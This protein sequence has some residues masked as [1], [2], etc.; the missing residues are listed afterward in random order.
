[1]GPPRVNPAEYGLAAGGGRLEAKPKSAAEKLTSLEDAV[2]RIK[3]GDHVAVGGCLFSRTPMA[4]VRELLRQRRRGLTLSRNLTCTEG[5]SLMVAGAV[6]R[7][8]T[9]WMS[10]GLPWGVSKILRHFVE[11]GRFPL[12]DWRHLAPGLRFRA[13]AMG[14]P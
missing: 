6:E 12:E 5:E 8:V 14:L 10:I 7:I 9:A 13:P 2:A 11:S 4:L 1:M 3:D